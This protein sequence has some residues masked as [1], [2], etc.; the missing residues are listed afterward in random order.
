MALIINEAGIEKNLPKL[1]ISIGIDIFTAKN[2]YAKGK[3]DTDY[4][5]ME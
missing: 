5:W 1:G 2:I 3:Q 4:T